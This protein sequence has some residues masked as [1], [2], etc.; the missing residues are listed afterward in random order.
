MDDSLSQY[1]Q[2]VDVAAGGGDQV[3]DGVD[4]LGPDG[5][6]LGGGGEV[7]DLIGT[8]V[9][10][11]AGG[12]HGLVGGD[13]GGGQR[14]RDGERQAVGD[15]G[16]FPV[17]GGQGVLGVGPCPC[18][19]FMNWPQMVSPGRARADALDHAGAVGA[20]DE[21][22]GVLD[23]ILQAPSA[24]FQSKGFSPAAGSRSCP[25]PSSRPA[26]AYARSSP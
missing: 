15:T 21:G 23:G 14:G 12:F 10:K 7:D 22:K 26:P 25:T 4:T 2:S 24:T 18:G 5:A 1:N 9:A 6:D 3:Q 16:H 20:H 11:A 19:R 17:L 8:E 13:A